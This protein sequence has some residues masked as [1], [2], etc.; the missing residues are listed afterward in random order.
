MAY[1]GADTN[2]NSL[3]VNG[4]EQFSGNGTQKIFLLA[5]NVGSVFDCN[6]TISGAVLSPFSA[7][8]VVGNIL[9][10]TTAPVTGTNNI[11]IVYR[12]SVQTNTISSGAILNIANSPD[13]SPS[14]NTVSSKATG[15]FAPSSGGIGFSVDGSRKLYIDSSYNCFINATETP[16]ASVTGFAIM[17]AG[18]GTYLYNSTSSTVYYP[19]VTFYNPNG[20]IGAIYTTGSATTYATS[21]DYR[22][23]KSI[24]PMTGGLAKVNKLNPVT[25]KW[26]ADNSNGQGFIAH[27]LQREVPDC[28]IGEKDETD[29]NGNP[30]YQSI[31]TSFLIATI[32]SAIQE[33]S[34]KVDI[35]QTKIDGNV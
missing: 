30:K 33:L 22:L 5:R 26:K 2:V 31:D 19:H 29:S 15:I 28:V 7:Y 3:M 35:L 9:T 32:T 25:Y 6:V 23:K 14:I 11:N 20:A 4:G 8:S 1:L 24:K 27:E 21:S 17:K 13:N 18:N 16:S 12:A 34:A 10:F